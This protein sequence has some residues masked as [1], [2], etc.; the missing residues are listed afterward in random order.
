MIRIAFVVLALAGLPSL[1]SGLLLGLLMG[2][3]EPDVAG[4]GSTTDAGAHADPNGSQ[5]DAGAH[6]DPNG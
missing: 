5:T 2:G 1:D 3:S 4:Q 6:A